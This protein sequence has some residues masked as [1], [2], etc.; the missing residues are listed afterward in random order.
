MPVS[1]DACVSLLRSS[2]V[3]LVVG[4]TPNEV[5][6]VERRF[7]FQFDPDHRALLLSAV[8]AGERWID[9]M[10]DPEAVLRERLAWPV[11]GVLF[12]VEQNGFWAASWGA[13][14]ETEP[15][16]LA[17]ARQQLAEW[18]VLVPI[19]GHRYTP[20]MPV[21]PGAPVFSTHQTDVI[22]Y[23]ADLLDYLEHEFRPRRPNERLAS[24]HVPRWS[25]LAEGCGPED[26]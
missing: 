12:D 6:H 18:P 10:G 9:W 23:G 26:L 24:V 25:A 5:E 1:I 8:P 17:V 14:P 20:A 7:G 2:G 16:A 4:L 21:A 3:D 19:Y 15:A 11:D 13:R 22:L